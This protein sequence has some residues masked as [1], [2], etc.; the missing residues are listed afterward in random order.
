MSRKISKVCEKRFI[1]KKSSWLSNTSHDP[2]SFQTELK[3][4]GYR[5]GKTI[6]EAIGGYKKSNLWVDNDS[7]SRQ[8]SFE[9]IFLCLSFLP[10]LHKLKACF[11]MRMKHVTSLCFSNY[12]CRQYIG[13]L[14]HPIFEI[15]GDVRSP[16]YQIREFKIEH[17]PIQL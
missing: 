1:T 3:K 17:S 13:C 12:V 10:R 15:I 11:H 7:W 6:I 2:F 16:R 8:L 9:N 5:I 4:E 14:F